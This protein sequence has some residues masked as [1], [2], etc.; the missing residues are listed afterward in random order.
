MQEL[1]EVKI[2]DNENVIEAVQNF[3][4]EKEITLFVPI[5]AE[6]SIKNFAISVIGKTCGLQKDM[7]GRSYE[8]GSMSGKIHA[9]KDGFLWDLSVVV[10]GN[11]TGPVH[12]ALKDAFAA[13]PVS[14]TFRKINLSQIKVA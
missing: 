5:G 1:V 3:M 7:T 2:K 4:K 11:G 13:G 12:G 14:L 8:I 10:R 6:G 9:L